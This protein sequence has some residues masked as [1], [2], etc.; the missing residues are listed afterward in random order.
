M[1]EL[2][3]DWTNEELFAEALKYK[4]RTEFVTKSCGAYTTATRRGI[5]DQVCAH[6]LRRGSKMFRGLYVF[7][8]PIAKK[9]YVGLTFNYNDRY[10]SHLSKTKA[11][12][13]M[14]R[15]ESHVFKPLGEFYPKDVASIKEQELMKEYKN[16]GWTLLN[17]NKGGGLGGSELKWTK[18]SIILEASKYRTRNEFFNRASGAY[19]AAKRIGVFEEA[20]SHMPKHASKKKR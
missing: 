18:E 17:K 16:N 11:I 15:A 13:S 19:D 10:L 2:H 3:H 1:R 9:V 6:M 7:E 20:C 12:I 4:D 5:L 14:N 8:Y